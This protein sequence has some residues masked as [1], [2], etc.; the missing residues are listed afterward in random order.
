MPLNELEIKEIAA[1]L[2]Q[3]HGEMGL[4]VADVMLESNISMIRTAMQALHMRKGCRILEIGHGNGGHLQEFYSQAED[5]HYH[6]LELSELMHRAA[7]NALS[8][9]PDAK[10]TLSLYDGISI[11]YPNACFDGVFSV[12]TLYFWTAPH[13]FL[14]EIHRVLKPGAVFALCFGCRSYMEQLPFARYGFS[15]Y[16][17]EEAEQMAAK[18]GFRIRERMVRHETVKGKTSETTEREYVCLLLENPI[19]E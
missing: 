8:V 9:I 12:N 13:S 14:R 1:Q 15:L 3:P 11:P 5:L 6:G 17:P 2:R 18:A 10:G 19:G 4:K 16:E 7:Q